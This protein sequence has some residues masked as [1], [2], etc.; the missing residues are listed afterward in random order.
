MS[1]THKQT[2]YSH[3]GLSLK[4]FDVFISSE[5]SAFSLHAS[6]LLFSLSLTFRSF[7]GC[8]FSGIDEI[9]LVF[10]TF[11]SLGPLWR[12]GWHFKAWNSINFISN[13]KRMKMAITQRALLTVTKSMTIDVLV[14]QLSM[15]HLQHTKLKHWR[16]RCFLRS[17][18]RVSSGVRARRDDRKLWVNW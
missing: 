14:M 17:H 9:F 13:L 3:V 11:L 6:Q 12:V 8:T 1:S 4:V 7:S 2:F 15:L 16:S 5:S 18:K 10:L